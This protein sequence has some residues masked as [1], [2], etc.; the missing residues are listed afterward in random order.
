[1]RRTD[2]RWTMR[3]T[4]WQAGDGKRRQGRQRIRW[5]DEIPSYA[6]KSWNKQAGNIES[7]LCR[8]IWKHEVIIDSLIDYIICDCIIYQNIF[9]I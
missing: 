3:V 4:E 7:E 9:H 2:N 6:G 1:M 8:R 5:R